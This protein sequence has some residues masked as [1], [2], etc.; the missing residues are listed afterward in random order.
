M[1]GR[2]RTERDL[3]EAGETVPMGGEGSAIGVGA[4]SEM[5]SERAGP[6]QDHE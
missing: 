2:T 6:A 1:A 5:K 3:G 4:R